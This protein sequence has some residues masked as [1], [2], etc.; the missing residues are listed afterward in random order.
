LEYLTIGWAGTEAVV[1]LAA[2]LVA[3]SVALVAFGADSGIELVSAVVVTLRLR[4]LIDHVPLDPRREHRDHR[5]L[6]V[7]FF[8]LALY[9]TISA[10]VSLANRDHP[11]RSVAGLVICIAAAIAMP[12]LA[13]AKRTT[14]TRLIDE[15][16]KS[17]GRLVMAD[18][19][20]SALCGWLSV[21]TL[22]GVVLGSWV[23]WWWADPIAGLVVVLFAV[24][25]GHEEWQCDPDWNVR[26]IVRRTSREVRNVG[27]G[28]IGP[29][30]RPTYLLIHGAWGGSWCWRDLVAEFERRGVAWA[31]VDLP[32]SIYGVDAATDLTDDVATVL[33]LGEQLESVLIV[34]HSYGGV[35]ATESADAMTNLKG[36]IYV[37]AL[38]PLPGAGATS[39]VRELPIMTKLDEAIE[40][41]GGYFRLNPEIAPF[42]IYNSCSPEVAEWATRMLST[43]TRASFSSLRTAP[44]CTVPT[45]Y[46]KCSLD[47]A[48]DPQLQ[49][50]MA[51]RCDEAITL[52]SDHSPMLSQPVNLC[53]TVLAWRKSIP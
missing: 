1:A 25:E 24:R 16:S 27:C 29:M 39:T 22:L 3:G 23:G 6:A 15:G 13:Y 4:A 35:V 50:L 37:S 7:L 9:V 48:V 34:A 42:A 40:V 28:N 53:H 17:V 41:D 43:Q 47:H 52:E 45:L 12:L 11:T 8:L 32:S 33:A 26:A 19:T 18:A 44:Q 20:E 5:I 49:D 2:G 14:A 51:T 10:A 38:I 36:I 30:T 46:V 31:V 21:S